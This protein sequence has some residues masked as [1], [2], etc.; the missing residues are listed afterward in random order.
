MNKNSLKALTNAHA[1]VGLVI[2]TI[3]F[4]IFF[5]GSISLFRDDINAWELNPHFAVNGQS[6]NLSFDSVINTVA[7][8]YNIST[9]GY[10]IDAKR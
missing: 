10:F 8:D 7:K 5:A 4:I 2:S 3:L 9:H 6:E 1:W